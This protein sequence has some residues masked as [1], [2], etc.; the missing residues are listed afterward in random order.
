MKYLFFLLLIISSSLHCIENL[1]FQEISSSAATENKFFGYITSVFDNKLAV[2]SKES[3]NSGSVTYY[4]RDDNNWIE[5][6]IISSNNDSLLFGSSLSI[7]DE[8]LVI[9][10][11]DNM[12]NG[13]LSSYVHIYSVDNE[14]PTL[15]ASLESPDNLTNDFGSS[16]KLFNDWLFIG[17]QSDS[18]DF[19]KSGAVYIYK[20]D[21]NN[22]PVY[23]SKI[24]AP[25]LE[26]SQKFGF[27]LDCYDNHLAV[28][29]PSQYSGS[30]V[31]YSYIN[32]NDEW[33]FQSQVNPND[34][35]QSILGY[36]GFTLSLEN[37]IMLVGAP[38]VDKF[39]IFLYENN[40]WE[41]L[42]V[43]HKNEQFFG[44]SI[45]CNQ[46]NIF[47]SS[48]ISPY[49]YQYKKIDNSW[50]EIA[51]LAANNPCTYFGN[52]ISS[53]EDE[54][55]IGA[56]NVNG[57]YQNEGRVFNYKI[58]NLNKIPSV[59]TYPEDII[60]GQSNSYLLALDSIF[61]DPDND[62]LIYSFDY[63][64]SIFDV[65]A[66]NNIA[67]FEILSTNSFDSQVKIYAQDSADAIFKA[68]VVF[69][70]SKPVS[71]LN[72]I[73]EEPFAITCY[74][75]P[76]NPEIRFLISSNKSS[77][78]K[79]IIYNIKG[80]LVDTVYDNKINK[81]NNEIIWKGKDS[82]NKQV[83]SGTYICKFLFNDKSITKKI[84]L[85]K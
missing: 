74:P 59:L 63:D 42:S 38:F 39:F 46:D 70:I 68:E 50:H 55:I 47:V 78:M 64:S 40:S 31:V 20:F 76:F 57:T 36:F 37:N 62:S 73:S 1:P 12:L 28:S 69:N 24:K 11:V 83:S 25:N 17:A 3:D 66:S 41:E 43:V 51:C 72:E 26:E 22:M 71:N 35:S 19:Y 23:Q 80:E 2:S 75:N 30:G 85:L 29:A 34:P 16:V 84:V 65:S 10:E 4:T 33:Q 56:T 7:N 81:G 61:M 9:G 77:T 54:I 14:T 82:N 48:I 60:L 79:V 32:V 18:D 53:S 67:M 27:S 58:S 15:I 44:S 49:V 8:H 6:I 52:H 45:I 5:E 21:N 13:S